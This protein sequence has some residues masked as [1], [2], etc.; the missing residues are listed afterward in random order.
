MPL[1][2][3]N[4]GLGVELIANKFA[5][6]DDRRD[7]VL[8]LTQDLREDDSADFVESRHVK[9]TIRQLRPQRRPD[10]G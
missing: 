4:N 2:G 7:E 6:P 9:E 1:H 8:T 5:V 3:V 10:G